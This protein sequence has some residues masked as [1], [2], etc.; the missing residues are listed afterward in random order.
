MFFAEDSLAWR[1]S[2][3]LLAAA[4]RRP[5]GNRHVIAFF[6][7]NGLWNVCDKGA[8]P[9]VVTA[10]TKRVNGGTHGLDDRLSKFNVFKSTMA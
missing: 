1:P 6:E 7:K 2:G 3:N 8:T 4:V 5:A 9:E 10:V